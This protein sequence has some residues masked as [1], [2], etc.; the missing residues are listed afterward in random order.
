MDATG[1]EPVRIAPV[2]LEVTALTTRPNILI[3]YTIDKIFKYF[4]IQFLLIKIDIKIIL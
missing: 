2:T 4:I 3:Q 1:F